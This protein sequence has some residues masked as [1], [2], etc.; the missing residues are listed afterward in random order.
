MSISDNIY[1][2]TEV[3]RDSIGTITKD[4]ERNWIYPRKPK[5]KLT[6][7][8][9]YVSY[10]LLAFLFMGPFIKVGGN[11]LFL[12]N[13]LEG[14]FILFGAVFW[15]QD[16]HL[17]VIAMITMFI[18]I[19]LFTVVYGRI[20]CGWACPQTIFMEMVFRK[21]EYWIEGDAP[22]QKRLN[23]AP[24]TWNKALKK[25]SKWSIF[26]LF[27]FFIANLL[28][29]YVIGIESLTEI[30]VKAP[31]ENWGKFSFVLFFSG[32]FFFV[33]TWFR[34][35]ACIAVCPYGRLQGVLLGKD[36]IV[37]A[38]D[39]VRGEP[40]G[41]LKKGAEQ[42]KDLG[43]CIDCK[44]C[45]AVCPTG[46]DIRHGTQMECVNCT[47]CIDACDSIMDKVKRPR[48][49]IRYASYN[50]I[51]EGLPFRFTPRMI[52]Y[53][54]LLLV[55]C[56]ALVFSFTQRSSIETTI[57][58]TSGKLYTVQQEGEVI[59]MY[60]IQLVNKQSN[61]IKVNIQLASHPGR[62]EIIGKEITVPSEGLYKGVILVHIPTDA[63]E[64]MKNKIS[65]EVLLEDKAIDQVRS[66]FFGP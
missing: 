1:Q 47:A 55:L 60:N 30:V 18:A 44:L 23:K 28:L 37:V 13:F 2:D 58:R 16:F 31:G 65:F 63:L 22:A 19:V 33:F 8:R 20:W 40:R 17:F 26:Y 27:S 11:P 50:N 3:F 5:G 49:L 21:I 41:K 62:V 53:T 66:N 39:H 4:G 43:D 25:A 45:V 15:P 51:V 57:L 7:Y 6:Q 10:I 32:V 56:T 42:S 48:G 9:T 54:V 59:N 12:F 46:I 14:K 61:E 24:W 38:Y 36:S 35:Q 34:E 52:S 29:A 64:G